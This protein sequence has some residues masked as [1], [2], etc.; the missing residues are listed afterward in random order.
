MSNDEKTNQDKGEYLFCSKLLFILLHTFF[1]GIIF[2]NFTDITLVMKIV[3]SIF[4]IFRCIEIILSICDLVVASYDDNVDCVLLPLYKHMR[5]FFKN[6]LQVINFIV[7]LVCLLMLK[8]FWTCGFAG[9]G[10]VICIISPWCGSIL[11]YIAGR[12][13]IASKK[14]KFSTYIFI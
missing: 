14:Q 4:I 10:Y 2:Y 12:I 9:K 6:N 1:A 8:Q 5:L 7:K 13:A 11:Y 3:I